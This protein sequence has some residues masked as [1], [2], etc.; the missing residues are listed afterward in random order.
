MSFQIDGVE[1]V[2]VKNPTS[3]PVKLPGLLHDAIPPGG[4]V[5]LPASYCLPHN[6]K[7]HVSLLQMAPQLVVL[8]DDEA[9][10][11]KAKGK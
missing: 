8:G 11:P 9:A 4:V 5:T 1:M 3:G 2:K 6:E 10:E 7:G